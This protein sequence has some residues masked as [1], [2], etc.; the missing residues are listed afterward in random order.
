MREYNILQS[1]LRSCLQTI[2]DLEPDLEVF[3][4]GYNFSK[5]ISALKD[6]LKNM[7]TANIDEGDVLRI[8]KATANFLKELAGPLSL[9]RKQL[10][11]RHYM[12]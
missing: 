10:A 6:F 3:E 7:E 12:Q 4:S 8:E 9:Y 2:L 1:R 11:V 5:D